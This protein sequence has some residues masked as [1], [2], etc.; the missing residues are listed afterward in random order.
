MSN[1][2]N[3]TSEEQFWDEVN[4]SGDQQLIV[5]FWA[6][7]CGPCL[8]MAPVLE[9]LDLRDDVRVLKVDVD[10][11]PALAQQFHITSIPTLRFWKNGKENKAVVRGVASGRNILAHVGL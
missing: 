6:T 7:W 1:I 3:I 8:R 5:D 2:V 9:E 11:N 10:A 4:A